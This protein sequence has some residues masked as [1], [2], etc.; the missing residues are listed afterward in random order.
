[1][2]LLANLYLLSIFLLPFHLNAEQPAKKFKIGYVPIS[3][4]LIL[5]VAKQRH[6]PRY[7]HSKL[8]TIKFTDWATMIEALRS[9]SLDGAFILGP[10]AFQAKLSGI[11]ITNVLL[12]HRD[13]L[14]YTSPSPRDR[15]KSRMPSSA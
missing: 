4:H 12:G 7:K 11:E 2:K 10:L 1:M 13:C 9:K 6:A 8:E 15:Q 3:D 14:L 5:G